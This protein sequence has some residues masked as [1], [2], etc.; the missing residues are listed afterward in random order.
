MTILFQSDSN[1]ARLGFH[2]VKRDGGGRDGTYIDFYIDPH[3]AQQTHWAEYRFGGAPS[4]R[5]YARCS[6]LFPKGY[7]WP[8]EH[9]L[10]IV[11]P[12]ETGS[13]HPRLYVNARGKTNPTLAIYGDH[14]D[15]LTPPV[16][17]VST[18]PSVRWPDDGAWHMLELT[19]TAEGG[20][21]VFFDGRVAAAFYGPPG[22]TYPC[23][24]LY[25]IRFGAHSNEAVPVAQTFSIKDVLIAT[26]KPAGQEGP[27]PD[28]KPPVVGPLA[29]LWSALDEA[30]AAN[31]EAF[32]AAEKVRRAIARARAAVEGK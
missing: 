29:E 1:K 22:G 2:D 5:F 10:V 18:E 30:Q 28:P 8:G 20:F 3:V 32:Q 26:E 14:W 19:Y 16:R 31:V 12:A 6:F 15:A 11:E 13:R 4:D 24:P 25:G 7:R 9:K 23:G 27:T 17:W 21:S